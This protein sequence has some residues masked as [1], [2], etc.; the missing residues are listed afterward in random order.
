MPYANNTKYSKTSKAIKSKLILGNHTNKIIAN[1]YFG[2]NLINTNIKS[3]LKG[4][5]IK[6][7]F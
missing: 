2:Y 3:H 1:Y 6:S 4:F 5:N 7:F